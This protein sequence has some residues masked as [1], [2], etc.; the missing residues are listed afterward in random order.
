MNKK[1]FQFSAIH[2]A[3]LLTLSGCGSDSS[4]SGASPTPE[5]ADIPPTAS[6]VTIEGVKQSVPVSGILLGNDEDGDTLTYSFSGDDGTIDPVDGVYTFSHGQLTLSGDQFE[7]T[8]AS[9]EDASITY[10]VTANGASASSTIEI[11][12]DIPPT[13]AD[14]TV[15]G[16]KQWIPISGELQGNDQDGDALTF[17]FSEN[18][19]AVNPVDDIYTFSHGELTLNENQF[20]YTSFSGE[21]ASISYTVTANDSSAS[22]VIEIINVASDPLAYQQWHLRNTGQRAFAL[23]DSVP[24][25]MVDIGFYTSEYA[26]E[27]YETHLAEELIA[28]EDMNVAASYAQGVT[29][30]GVTAVVVD[31]GL[32]IRHED[33]ID[34]VLVNRSL[35]LSELAS[36]RTDPTSLSNSGDHGTSVAGLIAA[37]G[38][39]NI[40]TR[41]VAP[42]TGLI[43]MNYLGDETIEQTELLIHGFPG[44]GIST[45][46]EISAFN[47]SYGI[48]WPG[49]IGYS[50]LDEAIESYPNLVLRNGKGALNIK[51]NGNGFEG[52]SRDGYLCEVN[53]AVALGLTCHNAAFESSQAHPYYLGIAAVNANGKHTSYSTAGASTM[54][55][56]PAGEYGR[57]APA[58]VTTDQMTCINGY[59]GFN[60][61]TISAWGEVYGLDFVTSQFPFN[62]PGHPENTSCN[63]TSTFNGTSSAAPNTSGVVS[64]I[65]SAN[66]DLTWRDVRH[67]LASTSTLIDPDN[68][69]VEIT[70]G[71]DS[72]IAHDGWVENAAGYQFN[73]LYG[74]GR[75][76]A[77][78]AVNMALNYSEDLGEQVITEWQGLGSTAGEAALE[79][80]IP[81]NSANGVSLQIEVAEDITIEAMQFEFDIRNDDMGYLLNET[82]LSSA[83][84]DLA[85]EVI[86]PSGTR[87]VLLSSKQALLNPS[88][89]SADGFSMGYI[90]NGAVF[91]S[92][93]FYGE[94]AKGTWTFKALDTGET[95]L[96]FVDTENLST[97]VIN[98]ETEELPTGLINNPVESVLE[99][100][101]LRTF[102]RA[103]QAAQ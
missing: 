65:L 43:G 22:A 48:T 52:G 73:N 27:K 95:N 2:A 58:M 80:T 34:N 23:S 11:I 78:A 57:W 9:G 91:L 29:G 60:G 32:E 56:A 94:N 96:E 7:Y 17:S 87:S 99:G 92:N 79:E 63:Y 4:S 90:L 85:L 76:D 47:R 83:G 41:G 3:I 45:D 55:S 35:N 53:G 10:T 69:A 101:S 64:L 72:F 70:I 15:D 49:S 68:E 77:G 54:V 30:T 16:A 100:V 18:E 82:S 24:Q 40:G 88:W 42:D 97:I 61:G 5:P 39:N 62:Y 13:A 93:A 86:S 28:G 1:I 84:N 46:E 14:V 67:I 71:E 31:S 36:D 33:L 50:Y 74:F 102:G 37:K 25:G 21:N 44:S 26:S 75:V 98:E 103:A 6:T 59:S 12:A 20:E 89:S 8:S 81:D 38:W 19:A 66:P 51:S